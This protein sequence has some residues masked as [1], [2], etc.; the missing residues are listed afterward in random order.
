MTVSYIH[1]E[2]A[3]EMLETL[4]KHGPD[5]ESALLLY[6]DG[7]GKICWR[8][9]DDM[10]LSSALWMLEIVKKELLESS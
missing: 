10:K 2:P 9:S 4:T 3:R 1:S 6:V 5:M 8:A 7:E